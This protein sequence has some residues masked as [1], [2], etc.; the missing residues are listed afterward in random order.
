MMILPVL[1]PMVGA[2][3]VFLLAG[4]AAAVIGIAT[5]AATL[6][7][8]LWLSVELRTHGVL[9]YLLG[10]WGAPLGIRLYADGLSMV[11]LL[12]TAT[13]G[14]LISIYAYR[15]RDAPLIGNPLDV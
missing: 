3:L 10:G 11:M 8:V 6:V 14:T 5:A 7:A 13:V 1:L 15:D 12:M 9:E 2:L 4:R